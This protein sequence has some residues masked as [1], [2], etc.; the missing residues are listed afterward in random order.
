MNMSVN[1]MD[2]DTPRANLSQLCLE[3]ELEMMTEVAELLSRANTGIT[4]VPRI[5]TFVSEDRHNWKAVEV[6]AGLVELM[7]YGFETL[8]AQLQTPHKE[9]RCTV[10]IWLT[11]LPNTR[12][13]PA[14]QASVQ[15]VIIAGGADKSLVQ[16][17][18]VD[19]RWRGD[20]QSDE[21]FARFQSSFEAFYEAEGGVPLALAH[22]VVR[23]AVES[24]A[25]SEKKLDESASE[26]FEYFATLYGRYLR[27]L[28]Y[29]SANQV[30]VVQLDA[31]R[32]VKDTLEDLKRQ[33]KASEKA[34]ASLQSDFDKIQSLNTSLLE[35]RTRNDDELRRL[36]VSVPQ[37]F[38]RLQG[39]TTQSIGERLDQLF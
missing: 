15:Y 11:A 19:G 17:V 2:D 4:T 7:P 10:R 22:K 13:A 24:A 3:Q 9:A 1:E 21:F 26:I 38:S 5:Y 23:D 28:V 39:M 37:S 33:L 32:R 34:R 6:D 25:K 30:S 16:M 31:A 35:Q 12:K 14:T 8:K 29:Q 27:A 36:R 18:Y 20:H